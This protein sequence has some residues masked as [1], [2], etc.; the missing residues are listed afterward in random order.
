MP[1]LAAWRIAVP[2]LGLG[3]AFFAAFGF[4]SY[5]PT[6]Q[7]FILGLGWRIQGGQVPYRDFLSLRP[8]LTPYLHSLWF[9]LP[10]GWTFPGARLGYYLQMT[11]SAV[12]PGL[13]A[14]RAGLVRSPATVGA[15]SAGF[16]A[17]ALHNFP[18]MP[19]HTVDGV[20]FSSLALSAWLVSLAEADARR[21]LR[22]RAAAS[23]GFALAMLCKQNFVFPA[24]LFGL[25]CSVEWL[26]SSKQRSP[27]RHILLLASALPALSLGAILLAALAGAGLLGTFFDQITTTRG[28][29]EAAYEY[30]V[31]GWC[32]LA[33]LPGLAW[34]WLCARLDLRPNPGALGTALSALSLLGLAAFVA[35]V[36]E[37]EQVGRTLL[38]LLLGSLLT[39]AT[40]LLRERDDG[41]R[42]KARLRLLLSGGVFVIG[43][44]ASLS[45]GYP[46]P[47]LGLGAM[48]VAIVDL[49]PR[50]GRRWLTPLLAVLFAAIL[51]GQS[52]RLNLH[53]PYFEV[54]RSRQVAA[55]HEIF[56]RFG[57]LW[58][59]EDL[60]D[61]LRELRTL[62]QRHALDPGRDF[63]VLPS[64]P[65][66]HHLVDRQSPA[67]LDWY[68]PRETRGRRAE[69]LNQ[70]LGLHAVLLLHKT[71]RVPPMGEDWDFDRPCKA[72]T[73]DHSPEL[74]QPIVRA[75]TLLEEGRYFCVVSLEGREGRS[76]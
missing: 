11:L 25:C 42:A 16:L 22:W 44:T 60:A 13:A 53:R 23:V 15:L 36:Q 14:H 47:N 28:L 46:M 49:L 45:W 24:L 56:P 43:W 41:A 57:R 40:L 61:Q 1:S 33:I 12:L 18:A 37:N 48:A 72:E 62:V 7:G 73:F 29:S 74:L 66:I 52:V 65:L 17:V 68:Y 64:F 10:E 38:W 5:H 71:R 75:G 6:D 19:W 76:R 70:L 69:V 39:R 9:L 8:P 58:S 26:R 51:I 20:F 35:L 34:P 54:P 31:E 30:Y 32:W 50:A 3:L 4:H 21:S 67:L 2:C 63:T 55:L 27:A 59:G